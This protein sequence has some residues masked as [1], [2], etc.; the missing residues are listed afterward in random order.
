MR[1]SFEIQRFEK[2]LCECKDLGI[3]LLLSFLPNNENVIGVVCEV[4]DAVIDCGVLKYFMCAR[5][6]IKI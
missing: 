5:K 6:L 3:I 1:A 4:Q 2:E